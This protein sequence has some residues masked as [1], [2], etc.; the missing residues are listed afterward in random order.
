MSGA[1]SVIVA[2]VAAA[3]LLAGG[4]VAA[5]APA[6]P[7]RAQA[8]PTKPIRLIIPYPPGGPRDLQARLLAP[9]LNEAW[10]QPIVVDNRAGAS[11]M[12][13]M[14]LAA[15]SHPDGHTVVMISAA[16]TTAPSL[17]AKLPYDTFRDFVAVAPLTSGPGLLVVNN[18]LPVKSVKELIALAKSRPGQLNFGS[19][20]NGVPSHL[21]MELFKLMTGTE[22][23]HVPYKGMAAALNDVISG[24]IQVS[25]PT[26]PGGLPHAQAGRVRALGVSGAHRSPAAPDIPTIAEAGI[27]G[28][29]S[30]NWYGLSAPAGTPSAVVAKLNREIGRIVMAPDVKAKLLAIG[31]ESESS[32]PEQFERFL[33]N[34]VAKW[35]KVIKATGLKLE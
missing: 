31:M 28:Y 13:G 16:Y 15:K 11:G 12:I 23:T 2:R 14:E 20:G 35:A 30:T 27:P 7:A 32:T 25:L 1:R 24:Q 34:E 33:R 4:I 9:K 22:L 3:V 26:I 21:S 6:G 17:Y 10:G 18:A 29:E 5:A 8:F 19:A